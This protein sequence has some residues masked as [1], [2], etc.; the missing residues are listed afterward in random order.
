MAVP[1]TTL[2]RIVALAL[3]EDLGRGDITTEACVDAAASGG[4]RVAARERLVFCGADVASAVFAQLD[5]SV[6]VE[7]HV[8]EGAWLERG[9]PALSL[10]G[11]ARSLLGGERVLLNFVQRLS[12]IATLTRSYV[13]ALPAG[14]KTRITDTRKTTPGLRALERYAVRCGGGINHRDDLAAAILIKDNH[15]AAS[16]GVRQA[17]ERA[18]R[19]A[20][21]TSRVLC[22]VDSTAQLEE[23]LRAGAD[24]V[25]LDNFADD[26]L[27]AAVQLVAGRALIEVSGSVTPERVP[28]IARAGVDVI[29]VGALTHSARGVD[30]G[31][32]WL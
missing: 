29:S 16:G 6:R 32:D 20:P 14:C 31:M 2:S 12:G 13:D 3:D 22:E 27:A 24:I 21:H 28:T 10:H 4:A 7:R 8:A 18:K 25:L 17:I 5:P 19:Y 11:P 1:N 15:I 30:L 9:A 26:S 23:A